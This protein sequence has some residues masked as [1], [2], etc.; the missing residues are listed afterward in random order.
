MKHGSLLHALKKPLSSNVQE[1]L[2]SNIWTLC[3]NSS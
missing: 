2:Y 1:N 3:A